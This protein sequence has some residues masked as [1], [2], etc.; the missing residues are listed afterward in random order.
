MAHTSINPA[1]N[2]NYYAGDAIDIPLKFM[3]K[4]NDQPIDITAMSVEFRIKES[5]TDADA[6]ALVTKTGEESVDESQISFTDPA[7]GECT[8]HILTG[9]TD[10]AVVEDGTTIESKVMEWHVRVFDANDNRV[11]S[12]TGD[13]EMWAS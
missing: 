2:D 1:D 11:T 4:N 10:A 9:D 7:N 5:L 12:V 13:W 6:D 3:D 8:V